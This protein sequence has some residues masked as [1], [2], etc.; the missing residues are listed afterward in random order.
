MCHGFLFPHKNVSLGLWTELQPQKTPRFHPCS[1]SSHPPV[2]KRDHCEEGHFESEC[3]LLQIVKWTTKPRWNTVWRPSLSATKNDEWR[4]LT[5]DPSWSVRWEDVHSFLKSSESM[6]A[7]TNHSFLCSQSA[8]CVFVSP[9]D[10]SRWRG[11]AQSLEETICCASRLLASILA[12][13]DI[14]FIPDK[15]SLLRV[16]PSTCTKRRFL[17]NDGF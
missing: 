3:L 6:N 15:V 16:P 14:L 5:F 11:W 4:H 1:P 9:S 10:G 13:Q 8:N 12:A 2:K 7:N 17:T